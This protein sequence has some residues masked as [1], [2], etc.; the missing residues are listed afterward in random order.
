MKNQ[1]S[2][3]VI[4]VIALFIFCHSLPAQTFNNITRI[5]YPDAASYKGPSNDTGAIKITLPDISY[6]SMLR[7]RIEVYNYYDNRSFTVW[8]S[9]LVENSWSKCSA[10][11]LTSHNSQNVPVHFGFN[12]GIARVWIGNSNTKWKHLKLNVAEL[13]VGHNVYSISDWDDG[14]DIEMDNSDFSSSVQVTINEVLPL[15][16]TQ[17]A[18]HLRENKN[19][20]SRIAFPN[21]ATFHANGSGT[22]AIK[23]SLPDLASYKSMM[24]LRLEVFNYKSNEGFTAWIGGMIEGNWTHCSAQI[25]TNLSKHKY[26]VYYGKEN[27]RGIIWIG[28]TNTQWEHLKV[29]VAEVM[30]G[31]TTSDVEDWYEG[32]AIDLDAVDFSSKVSF[33]VDKE[34]VLPLAIPVG[35]SIHWKEAT[36]D[37][38]LYYDEGNIAIGTTNPDTF[39][40]AVDGAIKAKEIR[41]NTPNWPDYV[42]EPDY[43]LMPLEK[44]DQFIQKNGH[45][46]DIPDKNKAEKE[47]IPIGEM[48]KKFLEKMEEFTLYLIEINKKVERL[49][50][51]NQALKSKIKALENQNK[52]K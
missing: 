18:N 29:H 36:V 33:T 8:A 48:Q 49:E 16:K 27:G 19:S 14:W 10:Q 26:N 5:A 24:R 25:L 13:T 41:V 12:A 7:M 11:I 51:E 52:E 9:G 46:P 6:K 35:S 30:V 22:G 2:I 15:A 45:L 28:E 47:G 4:I 21:D 50:T 43:Q 38:N 44:L 40:L 23:I 42:F 17:I 3:S 37:T 31:H 20:V 34:D 32:W 39:K 1:N